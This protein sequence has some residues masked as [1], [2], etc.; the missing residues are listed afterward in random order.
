MTDPG[1]NSDRWRVERITRTGSTNADAIARARAGEPDG[2]VIVADHQ[3]AGRGRLDR[4]W[5]APEG[6]NLLVSLLMRPELPPDAWHRCST[7]VAVAAVDAC[8]SFGVF[9]RIKWPNDI[10]VGTDKL[11]GILAEAVPERDG[12]G[13]AVVVGLG[14]NVGWPLAGEYSGAT[15]LAARGVHVNRDEL[16]DALPA[17][18][19]ERAPELHERYLARCATVGR[20][21]R[22]SLPNGSV[23]EGTATTIAADGRL[24]LGT[25]DGDTRLL[26]VG[27]VV[28]A[29]L[30]A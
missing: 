20:R 9:A 27:D 18:V 19:D 22:V 6:T 15:S 13:G 24:V 26:S 4:R 1:A 30:T 7:A 28:H 25:D 12:A 5:E 29:T 3:T 10:V 23:V 21:V 8:A 2:L 17:R 16:L 11:A 14:L